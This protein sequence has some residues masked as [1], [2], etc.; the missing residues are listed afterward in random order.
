MF[1]KV[2]IGVTVKAIKGH[3]SYTV[4]VQI[5]NIKLDRFYVISDNIF[6]F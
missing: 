2:F 5:A 3:N 4:H 6:I 1:F